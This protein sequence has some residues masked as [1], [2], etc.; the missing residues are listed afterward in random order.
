MFYG[1]MESESLSD[2]LA[3]NA[4]KPVR[5]EIEYVPTSKNHPYVHAYYISFTDDEVESQ[6]NK[7]SKI[8]LP[9]WYQLFW[10][11]DTVYAIF[12]DKVFRLKNE[13]VWGSDAYKE[14]Q[15]YGG[16]HGIEIV[17]MDFNKNFARFKETLAK[18]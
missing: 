12:K 5:V 6:A 4:Y 18:K 11:D 17:Y 2:P 3:L 16:E 10:S 15:K 1:Y 9:E 7:I 14:V 13:H 8:T